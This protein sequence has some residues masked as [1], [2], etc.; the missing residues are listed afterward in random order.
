MVGE[1]QAEELILFL[2]AQDGRH[3]KLANLMLAAGRLSEVRNR[4]AMK[5]SDEVLRRR[6]VEEVI[7]YDPPYYC[8]PYEELSEAGPTR[9]KAAGLIAF[10]WRS[11]NT[12][13]WVRSAAAGD[14]D[15]IVRR[16]AVQEVARGWKDDAETLPLLKGSARPDEKFPVR[17]AAVHE[18]APGRDD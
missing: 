1:K 14:P 6:F 18:V 10:V 5:R 11:E 7:R 17:M 4:R 9:E 12:R 3:D 2:M 16:A 8:E 15:W 13:V